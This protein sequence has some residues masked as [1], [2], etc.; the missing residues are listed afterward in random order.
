[1]DGIICTGY[2]PTV[3]L[4]KIL[5]DYETKNKK[6]IHAVGIDTDPVTMKAIEDGYLEG[7]I[8]QNPYGHGYLSLLALKYMS[9]GYKPRPGAYNINAGIV[10]VTK[11]NLTT[12][13]N[14]L[15]KVTNQIKADMTKKYLTK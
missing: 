14:D 11:A 9:E 13:N 2:V 15:T 10:M 7:T 4:S 6:H 8:S 5:T 1:V 12:Y 3:A